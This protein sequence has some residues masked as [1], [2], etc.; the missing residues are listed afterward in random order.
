MLKKQYENDERYNIVERYEI[1]KIICYYLFYVT[2]PI[3]VCDNNL[4][5]Q[6]LSCWHLCLD[7]GLAHCMQL[8][9]HCAQNVFDLNVVN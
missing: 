1:I 8:K 4:M 9:K 3:N 6:E 2:D 5:P 7:V